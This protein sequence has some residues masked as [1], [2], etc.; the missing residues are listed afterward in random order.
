MYSKWFD[1]FSSNTTSS[2]PVTTSSSTSNK[3]KFPAPGPNTYTGT[4][5]TTIFYEDENNVDLTKFDKVA[6]QIY[7]TNKSR[8]KSI[9]EDFFSDTFRIDLDDVVPDMLYE[10]EDVFFP[11]V[12]E[13]YDR[14][15]FLS[16]AD[17][18]VESPQLSKNNITIEDIK[19]FGFSL[20]S[21]E[22]IYTLPDTSL[23][24]YAVFKTRLRSALM[25]RDALYRFHTPKVI[26]TDYTT[27][28]HKVLLGFVPFHIP[29]D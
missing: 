29:Q 26:S 14:A 27:G 23:I 22:L 1:A 15:S 5:S 18:K 3:I 24:K 6:E 16:L 10:K 12:L 8:I 2:G 25:S 20:Y 7:N 11:V 13:V 4:S 17:I 9:C 21:T 28:I 19:T